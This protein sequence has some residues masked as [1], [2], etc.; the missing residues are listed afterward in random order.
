MKENKF[1]ANKVFILQRVE[2]MRWKFMN[3]SCHRHIIVVENEK[4][5]CWGS[6][7]MKTIRNYKKIQFFFETFSQQIDEKR[8]T[9][10]NM[11]LRKKRFSV[12]EKNYANEGMSVLGW[13]WTRWD[14]NEREAEK[15]SL[16]SVRLHRCCCCYVGIVKIIFCVL[17]PGFWFGCRSSA[18]DVKNS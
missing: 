5:G 13:R 12:S 9:D 17:N 11:K 3:P 6:E 2:K 15:L 16:R 7:W 18:V 10:E 14:E 8:A 4:K 1:V